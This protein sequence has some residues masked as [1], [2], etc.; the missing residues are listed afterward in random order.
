ME[1]DRLRLVNNQYVTDSVHLTFEEGDQIS[2]YLEQL[3]MNKDKN[4]LE[5]MAGIEQREKQREASLMAVHLAER[6][7]D[8]RREQLSSFDIQKQRQRIKSLF[9][10]V[11]MK[12][13]L[14]KDF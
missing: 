3:K 5:I 11:K 7:A 6:Q 9:G 2:K 10:R 1:D 13:R 12:N 14:D 8:M 4:H